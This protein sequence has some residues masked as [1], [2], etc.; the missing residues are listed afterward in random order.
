MPEIPT[1]TIFD[2]SGT[3][4]A[5]L[6]GI[7][8]E[9]ARH[10]TERGSARFVVDREEW[11]SVASAIN[12]RGDRFRI[13]ADGETGWFG[14][15]FRDTERGT[16]TVTVILDDYERDA[17]D[18]QPTG[19]QVLFQNVDD[20]TVVQDA[21]SRI[22]TLSPG[23][24]ETVATGL[25]FSFANA[26]PAKMIRDA[27]QPGGA[28][29]RYNADRTVD[30][31]ERPAVDGTEP[32]LS[33]A[34]GTLV[35][36][37]DVSDD[38]RNPPTEIIGLGA[39]SGPNQ[40]RATATVDPNAARDVYRRYENKDI[41]Q[42][43]R[44]QTT[45]DRLAAEV[46]AATEK[47]DV[48]TEAV[49]LSVAPGDPIDF[50][51]PAEEINATLRV[52]EYTETVTQRGRRYAPLRVSNRWPEQGGAD[53]AVADLERFNRGYQGFIDR[54]IAPYGPEVAGDGNPREITVPNWPDDIV[55]EITVELT[56]QGSPWRSPVDDDGH[57][58]S[59]DDTT[60]ENTELGVVDDR[61]QD[62]TNLDL[63]GIGDELI[64]DFTPSVTTSMV[65]C[66]FSA[67]IRNQDETQFSGS[68]VQA[69]I[70]DFTDGVFW[71]NADGVGPGAS[72]LDSSDSIFEGT[73][74]AFGERS[75]NTLR[76][77]FN[78]NGDSATVTTSVSWNAIDVH[79]HSFNG[80]TNSQ[81]TL[82]PEVI[83]EFQGT[84]YYPDD[85]EIRVNGSLVTTVAGNDSAEWS[86]TVD[87]SGELTPGDNTITATPASR[88]TLNL[89]LAS[90]LFR[91]GATQ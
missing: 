75:G 29:V 12:R 68:S 34:T 11:Q 39:Q 88:G 6:A 67:R 89:I 53:K 10:V 74:I 48:E 66:N 3:E 63:D 73:I 81:A 41:Q 62:I 65:I 9:R 56:V 7:S 45:V 83:T 91:R 84:T 64:D 38:N 1:L 50:V 8:A 36:E 4:R 77:E 37:P 33:T 72:V 44:L 2:P 16:Q 28:L 69:R 82:V 49:S 24:I 54:D 76:L 55:N 47:L 14:G 71:P 78:T 43:S 23:T 90:E 20:A 13:D 30:F 19:G 31:I 22:P 70:Y 60:A 32:E 86:E 18:A 85:V 52:I 42:Q 79:T 59:I 80:T 26:E 25:S 27:A 5:T 21:L 46:A 51:W 57:I 15:R 17:R 61:Q 58:H 40:V 35:G 87:L